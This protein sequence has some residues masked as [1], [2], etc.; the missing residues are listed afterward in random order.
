V[1]EESCFVNSGRSSVWI[2]QNIG[3]IRSKPDERK[4]FNV[5]AL[6]GKGTNCGCTMLHGEPGDDVGGEFNESVEVVAKSTNESPI[7]FSGSIIVSGLSEE[8]RCTTL[9]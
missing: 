4:L 1:S 6:V 5:P 2:G 8:L 9:D 7:G 3:V